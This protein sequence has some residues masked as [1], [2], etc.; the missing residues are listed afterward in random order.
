MQ[1]AASRE[2]VRARDQCEWRQVSRTPFL[3][4]PATAGLRQP[5]QRE[6]PMRTSRR[7]SRTRIRPQGGIGGKTHTSAAHGHTA[8]APDISTTRRP[9]G[10]KHGVHGW[11]IVPEARPRR[12]PRARRLSKPDA[13]RRF[14]GAR[15]PW[16]ALSPRL[17]Q[18]GPG[19][20]SDVPPRV[21]RASDDGLRAHGMQEFGCGVPGTVCAVPVGGEQ[22]REARI[23]LA[24]RIGAR[25]NDVFQS[26]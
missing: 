25:A 16:H 22:V 24:G 18:D 10:S 5:S 7:P 2:R 14:H 13:K 20:V 21:R 23:C 8:R 12:S 9:A 6:A 17:A 26:P 1:G 4:V 11:T 19:V 15:G 3:L